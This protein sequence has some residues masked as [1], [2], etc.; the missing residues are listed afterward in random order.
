MRVPGHE[1]FVPAMRLFAGTK[2]SCPGTRMARSYKSA[3]SI[4]Q[5]VF[6]NH[7]SLRLRVAK[8]L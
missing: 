2:N 5:L 8:D 3:L 1:F 6:L 7:P 4:D